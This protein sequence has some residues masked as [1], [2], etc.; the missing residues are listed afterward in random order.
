MGQGR[1]G[2]K[3]MSM[4][5]AGEHERV[6]KQEEGGLCAC[7]HTVAIFSR[8]STCTSQHSPQPVQPVQEGIALRPLS[9]PVPRPAWRE[10]VTVGLPRTGAGKEAAPVSPLG[11]PSGV[12]CGGRVGLQE[13]LRWGEAAG[14]EQGAS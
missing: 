6:E 12:S 2:T 4:L 14:R 10:G 7:Q 1:V 8:T 5:S 3:K 13:L 9:Q 11:V